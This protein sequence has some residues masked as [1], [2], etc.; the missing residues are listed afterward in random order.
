MCYCGAAASPVIRGMMH[1][2][3][4][5][6]VLTAIGHGASLHSQMKIG[7]PVTSMAAAT[8]TAATSTMTVSVAAAMT[9]HSI[10]AATAATC[11][12]LLAREGSAAVALTSH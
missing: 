10:A 8:S 9:G 2:R 5:M 11:S 7:A 6:M 3:W 4:M 1:I 12:G